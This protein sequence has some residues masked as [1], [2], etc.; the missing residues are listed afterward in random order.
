MAKIGKIDKGKQVI[1]FLERLRLVDDYYGEPLKLED[2]QRKFIQKVYGNVDKQ[3]V[4]KV[5]RAL[6]YMPRG[7]AK[8]TLLAALVVYHLVGEYKSSQKIFSAASSLDQARL[9]FSYV[10][11][12]IRQIP[13]LAKNCKIVDHKSKILFKPRNNEYE[14]LCAESKRSHGLAASVVLCDETHLWTGPQGRALWAGLTTGFGKRREPLLISISTAG[15]TQDC[16]LWDELKLA[17]AALEDPKKYPSYYAQLYEL[18][19]EDDWE[20]ESNWYKAIPALG[21]F[22]NIQTLKDSLSEARLL[23]Q[24]LADF[25]QYNL[26]IWQSQALTWIDAETWAKCK[27]TIIDDDFTECEFVFAGLDLSSVGDL[28]ALTLVAVHGDTYKVKHFAW[29]P[30]ETILER[31]KLEDP[32]YKQWLDQGLLRSTKGKSIN[33]KEIRKEVVEICE[34]YNVSLVAADTWNAADTL[35]HLD[36]NGIETFAFS[37]TIRNFNLP[38]KEFERLLLAERI[39][40]DGNEMLAWCVDN[41]RIIQDAQDNMRPAKVSQDKRIDPVI[42][43]IMALGAAIAF[44]SEHG[45]G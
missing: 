29:V 16:V 30:E 43:L 28:T 23:P 26:N 45:L 4:R 39:H 2:F 33:L 13:Y 36:D 32:R 5:R 22:Y 18:T 6:L 15:N 19:N 10:C 8:T 25:K 12:M 34:R 9:M 27:R 24:R 14:A 17:R 21:K 35:Q 44:S 31:V 37:Q 40:H 3:G 42:C 11:N 1:D 20:K 41:T 38:C 7:C